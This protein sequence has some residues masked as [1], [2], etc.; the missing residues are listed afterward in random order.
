M[1]SRTPSRTASKTRSA[2]R[3]PT[4]SRSVSSSFVPTAS[5]QP[6]AA[7]VISST[8]ST[9][10]A[11]N[12]SYAVFSDESL[13]SVGARDDY[14]DGVGTLVA[15]GVLLQAPA[16]LP[17]Q[18]AWTYAL[19]R[20]DLLLAITAGQN[21]SGVADFFVS[22]YADSGDAA[23]PGPGLLLAAPW[24]LA[25]A[26]TTFSDARPSWVKVDVSGAGWPAL[27]QGVYFWVVLSPGSP[28]PIR[29][30]RP[31]G[32][33]GPAYNGVVWS[34]IN[35]SSGLL[36]PAVA[37]DRNL[38]TGRQL[39]SERFAADAAFGSTARASVAFLLGASDWAGVANAST[40]YTNWAA[41]GSVVRYGVQ[42][43][44]WQIAPER[45]WVGCP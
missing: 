29:V 8:R 34:G 28:L 40:R 4:P 18:L 20:I 26:S 17:G 42:V 23:A 25:N 37:A 19:A 38:F 3:V 31:S 9:V 35:A 39:V 22:L 36:P 43:L 30:P 2:S 13:A 15:T 33:L 5:R 24:S 21:R 10:D 6:G 1:A 14:G 7:V 32:G 44:G 16:A 41:S 11:F 27:A 45:E 12:L